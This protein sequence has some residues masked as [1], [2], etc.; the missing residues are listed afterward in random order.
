MRELQH[1]AI[2][3]IT[4][5][6]ST[7]VTE[8][9]RLA[10][11]HNGQIVSSHIQA[12]GSHSIINIL[13]SGNWGTIAKLESALTTLVSKDSLPLQIQRVSYATNPSAFPYMFNIIAV[14]DPQVL[15]K[16]LQFLQKESIA[17]HELFVESYKARYTQLAMVSITV[18]V[19]LETTLS[20]AE[21]REQFILFCDA[22]NFDAVMEPDKA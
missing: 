13:L 15:H 10:S 11:Q 1:L 9:A 17:I 19:Q 18:R 5:S 2:A 6:N 8:I 3:T 12:H 22:H 16:V 21:L 4:P 14:D 7:L 20:I